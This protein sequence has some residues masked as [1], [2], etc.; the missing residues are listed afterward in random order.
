MT[1][2][3]MRMSA[4]LLALGLFVSASAI[5]ARAGTLEEAMARLNAND[6]GG[7]YVLLK[8]EE[9][10]KAGNPDFDYALGLAA[11]DTGRGSEAVT[12]F[13]RVLAI[14]PDH[15]Q[16]RAELGR[17]YLAIN[18]PEAARREM[19]TV[20]ATEDV[21][22]EVRELL[23]RY[24]TALDTGLS[25]GGTTI[26]GNMT[27]KA[28]YDSNV[29]NSTSDSR[30][31][32]PAFAGLGFAT[33]NGSATKQDDG[34]AETSGRISVTHGIAIDQKII[35]ELSASYRGNAHEE[36]FN[37]AIAG[38]NIGF[39][40]STPDWGTFTLMG[41]AQSYWVDDDAYRYT[42]G[43][44]GQWMVSAK[45]KTD[46]SVFLQYAHQKY[47]NARIQDSDRVTLGATVGQSFAGSLKPYVFGGLYGGIEETE[48]SAVDHL[49]Y[50]FIGA[51]VGT[52]MQI[53]PVIS[54]YATAAIESDEYKSP[55]PL[56]L[57]E[58]STI[59]ADVS[60]GLRYA[61]MPNL[62][63]N[64]EISYT[65]ADSNI[66]LNKYD[67]FVGSVAISFDF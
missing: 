20:E 44:L 48:D 59:R 60:A 32:I 8:P 58:R 43:A 3:T 24:V 37:Q 25:G 67:R 33:L 4:G 36:Q 42:Y 41:Q 38:L 52:E 6:A 1:K 19:A 15:V 53:T 45:T 65:N 26:H 13:E 46:Y 23:T 2:I 29:N 35:A 51:R 49:S 56:F 28:G 40:Q 39:A 57:K 17:A 63:I 62:K 9:R 31:L 34:F 55:D 5:A 27:V 64:P 18:E 47:P 54:V 14:N 12:A 10:R 22:P 11:L 30:I 66:V 61:L 7:A 50:A 16:A 21:P